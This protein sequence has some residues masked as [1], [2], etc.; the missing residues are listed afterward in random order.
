[1]FNSNGVKLFFKDEGK[2]QPV[3]LV[4]GYLANHDNQWFKPGIAQALLAKGYRVVAL[5]SRG[6]GQSEKPLG[7][8][9]YGAE[10]SEDVARLLK[11]LRIAKAHV[12]GYS[13]GSW[14]VQKLAAD[15]PDLVHTLTVGG[16]GWLTPVDQQAVNLLADQLDRLASG[17]KN[18]GTLLKEKIGKLDLPTVPSEARALRD[19]G[20][21]VGK[22]CLSEPEAKAYPGPMLGL[23]GADDDTFRPSMEA[24]HKLRLGMGME[25]V[26]VGGDHLSA[27][28]QVAFV[29]KLD[30]F[31]GTHPVPKR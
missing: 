10:M 28:E 4:H 14:V 3:V 26:V 9:R 18:A 22:L 15:H 31:L 8:G 5:D 6:H 7:E 21:G 16:A 27:Y 29:K 25:L 2:G 23:I 20:R 11:H 24:L 19:A 13:M 17:D 30:E 1:M 12:V